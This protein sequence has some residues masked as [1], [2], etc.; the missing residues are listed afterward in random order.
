MSIG[1]YYDT[2][3]DI[4]RLSDVAGTD[5]ETYAEVLSDILCKIEPQGSEYVML[6]DGLFYKLFMMYCP[7]K[8]IRI[9]DRVIED[10]SGDVYTVKGISLFKKGQAQDVVYPHHLEILLAIPQV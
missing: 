1:K 7:P 6:A 3:V 4:E 5:K 8:D 2:T 10:V 9:G